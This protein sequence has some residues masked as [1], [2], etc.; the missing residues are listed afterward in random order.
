[1]KQPTFPELL[2]RIVDRERKR[3]TI[4]NLSMQAKLE[5][6]LAA[7]YFEDSARLAELQKR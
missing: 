4:P 7:A 1:M 2:R 5:A 6:M 3:S